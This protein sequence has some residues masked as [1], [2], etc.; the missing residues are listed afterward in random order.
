MRERRSRKAE[1][2]IYSSQEEEIT[3]KYGKKEADAANYGWFVDNYIIS[4]KV[5]GTRM[6]LSSYYVGNKIIHKWTE[7]HPKL[8]E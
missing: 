2:K 4:T 1:E 8:G 7:R 3:K 5:Y 6:F